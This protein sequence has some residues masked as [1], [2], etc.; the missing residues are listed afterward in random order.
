MDSL[1]F[2]NES[3]N[4]YIIGKEDFYVYSQEESVYKKSHVKV[5]HRESQDL[6]D[7]AMGEVPGVAE[8]MTLGPLTV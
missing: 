2:L 6:L 1:T 8:A 5:G 4:L 7:Q 3:P